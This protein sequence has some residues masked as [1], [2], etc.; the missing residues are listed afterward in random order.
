MIVVSQER[1]SP[2]N[3]SPPSVGQA[4]PDEYWSK[5]VDVKEPFNANTKFR[6]AQPDLLSL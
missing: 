5:I 1:R 4:L 3:I 2:N 6:Q